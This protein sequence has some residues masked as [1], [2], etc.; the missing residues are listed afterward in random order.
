MGRGQAL[1]LC[2]RVSAATGRNEP[3]RSGLVLDFVLD[4][5]PQHTYLD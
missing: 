1:E 3:V 4:G 2:V 5:R